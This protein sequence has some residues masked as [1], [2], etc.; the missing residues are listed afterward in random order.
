M[1]TAAPRPCTFP[2]CGALVAAGEGPRCEKHRKQ[3]ERA[4]SRRRRADPNNQIHYHQSPEWR[5]IRK[6]YIRE[7][8]L[9][10]ECERQGRTT[11]A[12][13]VDHVRALADGGDPRDPANLQSL[14]KSCHSRKTWTAFNARRRG[15]PNPST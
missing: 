12:T 5:A 6:A 15:R 7:R 10:A 13:E 2:R 1:P 3:E 11:A 14:C 4:R 8:P 9:C